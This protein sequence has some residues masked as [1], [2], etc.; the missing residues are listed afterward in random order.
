MSISL[1]GAILYI[2]VGALALGGFGD[3]QPSPPEMWN[4]SGISTMARSPV[5]GG[6]SDRDISDAA[7]RFLYT[8]DP[9]R[10]EL[11]NCTRR[12]EMRGVKGQAASSLHPVVH[13]AVDTML[14]AT[15]FLNLVFQ[16]N[17]I[18]ESSVREDMEWYH[19]LVRSM[20]EADP[21]IYRALLTLDVP[22]TPSQSQLVLQATRKKDA[23][24]LQDLSRSQHL[25][26]QT[27]DGDWFQGLK[28]QKVPRLNK[29]LL[30]ND[31]QTLDTPK[32]SQG[33]SYMVDK[34]HVKWSS[35]FLDCED[36][37]LLPKWMVTM[38]TSFYGLKP[39][40]SPEF[41]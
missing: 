5:G 35:P 7:T 32:W 15:N 29:R 10:L 23:I 12:V 19:A 13:G 4:G 2:H 34:S 17:D 33:D 16:T 3:L 21:N 18:R 9:A 39:D 6:A 1:V 31:L 41:K 24:L 36:E 22:A 8:G 14:H 28:F 38:S 40:L 27:A 37:K 26:N 20:V 11:V 30:H 25:K